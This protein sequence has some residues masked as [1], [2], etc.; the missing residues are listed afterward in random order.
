[1]L[2]SS[3]SAFF[4]VFVVA[5]AVFATIVTARAVVADQVMYQSVINTELLLANEGQHDGSDVPI[6]GKE[7]KVRVDW[8]RG[9]AAVGCGDT[10]TDVANG[11]AAESGVE[12]GLDLFFFVVDGGGWNV[13]GEVVVEEG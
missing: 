12:V 2:L 7:G 11:R 8:V 9:R 13:S 10:N 5:A 4:V 3:S 6:V 1:M